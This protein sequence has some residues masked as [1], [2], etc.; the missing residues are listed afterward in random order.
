MKKGL[1]AVVMLASFMLLSGCTN[2]QEKYNALNV[3]YQNLNGRYENCIGSL[4]DASLEKSQL[5]MSLTDQ[6]KRI[7][8]LMGQARGGNTGFEG[9]DVA[10]DEGAG[11][12][13]VTLPNAIL[14]SPGKAALRRSTSSEL[15]Q[16][17]SVIKGR[18]AGRDI[19]V[20]GHTDS[21]PIR[22]SAKLWKDNWE[23]SSERALTVLRYMTGKGILPESIR[24]AACGESRPVADN[25]TSGG[26]ARNRRVEIVIHMR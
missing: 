2:W 18:Y 11:T 23:L 7:N 22:K 15:D 10:V 17:L 25:G 14:F 3:E 26:K 13:T 9:M 8:D 24:A 5:S 19:D 16:V 1:L 12:I 20:V 4:D 6:Q 21:D